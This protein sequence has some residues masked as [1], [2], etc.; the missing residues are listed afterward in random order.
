MSESEIQW[1]SEA[2]VTLEKAQGIT[3]VTAELWNA[4]SSRRTYL[5]SI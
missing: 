4:S 5:I 1:D 3:Q 2:L